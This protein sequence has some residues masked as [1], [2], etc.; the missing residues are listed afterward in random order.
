M[1]S[2][3]AREVVGSLLILQ[4]RRLLPLVADLHLVFNPAEKTAPA[5]RSTRY[6]ERRRGEGSEEGW[7]GVDSMLVPRSSSLSSAPWKR[8]A[9]EKTAVSMSGLFAVE[10]GNGQETKEAP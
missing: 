1:E 3:H 10:G 6:G 7:V 2:Y 8:E 9:A 4:L 5:V